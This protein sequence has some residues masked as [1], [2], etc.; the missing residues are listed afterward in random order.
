M[1]DRVVTSAHARQVTQRVALARSQEWLRCRQE[2]WPRAKSAATTVVSASLHAEVGGET[3]EPTHV[4][5]TLHSVHGLV[6]SVLKLRR[7]ID[8]SLSLLHH[9]F[10]TGASQGG[11]LGLQ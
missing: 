1:L 5:A 2:V 11:S 10:A 6:N 3:A 4:I 9:N 8:P 7:S